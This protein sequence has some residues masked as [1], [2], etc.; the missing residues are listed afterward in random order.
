MRSSGSTGRGL[1]LLGALMLGGGLWLPWYRLDIPARVLDSIGQAS[2]QF[3]SFGGFLRA[4]VAQLRASGPIELTAWQAFDGLDVVFL[5]LALAAA[6]IALL[7]LT[8]RRLLAAVDD[9]TALML[10]GVAAAA[11]VGYRMADRPGPSEVLALANGIYVGLAG[12]GAIFAG[13]LLSRS[14]AAAGPATQA[15]TPR[16]T[17][18]CRP[19][20]RARGRRP[21]RCRRRGRRAELDIADSAPGLDALPE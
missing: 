14:A 18:G 12:A 16:R 10:L 9:G 20:R 15:P 5:G 19:R 1:A 3:G 17:A 11:L 2:S 4:G 8:G 13:G 21:A 7:E 6:A